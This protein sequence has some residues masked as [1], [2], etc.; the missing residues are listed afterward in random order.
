[1]TGADFEVGIDCDFH[2]ISTEGPIAKLSIIADR[3]SPRE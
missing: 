2:G 1:M 3:S